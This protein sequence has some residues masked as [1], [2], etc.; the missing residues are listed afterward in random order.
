MNEHFIAAI[1]NMIVFF[2]LCITFYFGIPLVADF[3]LFFMMVIWEIYTSAHHL[4]LILI[5]VKM[6]VLPFFIICSDFHRKYKFIDFVSMRLSILF[7]FLLFSNI[8]IEWNARNQRNEFYRNI[9]IELNLLL[10]S[11]K[12][13]TVW[14]KWAINMYCNRIEI[15]CEIIKHTKT[16][17]TKNKQLWYR[18]IK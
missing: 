9:W 8:V 16:L 2:I 13:E 11:T 7:F 4:M 14:I 1:H 6:T 5:N 12:I 10:L 3:L 17:K 15:A 18:E